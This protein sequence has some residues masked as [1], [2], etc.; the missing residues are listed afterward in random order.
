MHGSE[1]NPASRDDSMIT[2]SVGRKAEEALE[3]STIYP[4]MVRCGFHI[5]LPIHR[6]CSAAE[7]EKCSVRLHFS[8]LNKMAES[9]KAMRIASREGWCEAAETKAA[10]TPMKFATSTLFSPFCRRPWGLTSIH[11]TCLVFFK[12]VKNIT[13][14]VSDVMQLCLLFAA[15]LLFW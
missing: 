13:A 11:H 1:I 4:K 5:A 3:I 12:F 15:E 7:A 2:C 9:R 10:R 6:S 8:S 14:T